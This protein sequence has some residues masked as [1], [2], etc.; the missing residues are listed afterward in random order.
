MPLLARY[1]ASAWQNALPNPLSPVLHLQR[2]REEEEEEE[3]EAAAAAD[4][5]IGRSPCFQT[6][7]QRNQNE[8][9]KKPN[10]K[11]QATYGCTCPIECA[12]ISPA[13][14]FLFPNP[15]CLNT[16]KLYLVSFGSHELTIDV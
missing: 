16:L 7:Q 12:P 11:T 13:S 3:E 15:R 10:S 4:K 1:S 5:K 8:R 14:S 9:K 6:R 2:E